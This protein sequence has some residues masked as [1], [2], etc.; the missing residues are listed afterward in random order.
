MKESHRAALFSAAIFPGSGHIVLRRYPAGIAFGGIAIAC[1]AVLLDAALAIARDVS[2]RILS[3]EI[4]PDM[5]VIL[6][7][8]SAQSASTGWTPANIATWVLVLCWIVASIDAYRLGKRVDRAA[9]AG[10]TGR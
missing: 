9:E 4:A 6:G 10:A 2:D 8:I 3:G 7:E 5:G 1:L